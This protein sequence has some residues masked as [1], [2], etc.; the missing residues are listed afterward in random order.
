MLRLLETKRD[1]AHFDL[2]FQYG[3]S[4]CTAIL[5]ADG[6]RPAGVAPAKFA[7]ELEDWRFEQMPKVGNLQQA[8]KRSPG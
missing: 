7:D 8:L 2:R 3:D 1:G 6:V 4:I 5:D